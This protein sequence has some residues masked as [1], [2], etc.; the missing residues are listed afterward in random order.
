[1]RFR[2]RT[3]VIAAGIAPPALALIWFDALKWV[4]TPVMAIGGSLL[5]LSILL[6]LP[7]IYRVV[8]GRE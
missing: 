8:S 4:E 6:S 7:S 3:L 1:M 2:L 5:Y